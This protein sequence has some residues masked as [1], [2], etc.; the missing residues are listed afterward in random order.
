MCARRGGGSLGDMLTT[1]LLPTSGG[2]ETAAH[3]A[4]AAADARAARATA[5]RLGVKALCAVALF[6]GAAPAGVAAAPQPYTASFDG[7]TTT[8]TG[9]AGKDDISVSTNYD[10]DVVVY[11]AEPGP[12]CHRTWPDEPDQS[13]TICRLGS[14]GI[15]VNALGGDDDVNGT[16]SA[17]ALP[18][19]QFRFDLGDGND[20]FTASKIDGAVTVSG[21][22]GNDTIEGSRQDDVLDGGP[23]NDTVD[24]YWGVDVVRGGEGNDNI[25][26][27]GATDN[28]SADLIDGGPG[29]DSIDDWNDSQQPTWVTLDG[30]ANDGFEGEGDNVTSVEN[31]KAGGGLQFTG[32]DSRNVVIAGEVATDSATLLGLGGDDELTGT[33]RADRIEGGAGND[34]IIGGYGNDTIIGGPGQDDINGDRA[35]RCNEYHCDL[36]PGSAADTID[37]VDGERDTVKCGPGTDTLRADAIDVVDAD[38]ENV[39]RVGAPVPNTGGGSPNGGGTTTGNGSSNGNGAAGPF[40]LTST[41]LAGALK[42]G[43]TLKVTG[44]PTGKK[45][46]VTAKQG[47]STVAKG[48]AKVGKS[49]AATITLKFTAA[50][51]KKLK[52]AKTVTLSLHAGKLSQQVTLTR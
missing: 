35:G 8:I 40:A 43:L 41:K 13:P 19:S 51:K 38:C 33:D 10:G 21:G 5:A 22:L 18:A 4:R 44:Q 28:R 25:S 26:G 27:D 29:T 6:A 52:K 12:G 7:T 14:G 47:K 45:L 32:D 16:T 24:G 42:R 36:S 49:G 23:G 1:R 2:A 11:H 39:T 31:V 50:A 37:S 34:L 9:T 48:S 3:A 46:S 30:A 17:L 15:Q 20:R